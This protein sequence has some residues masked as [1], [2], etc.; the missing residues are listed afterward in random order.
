MNTT[1]YQ[2]LGVDVLRPTR[3]YFDPYLIYLNLACNHWGSSWI[4]NKNHVNTFI[5]QQEKTALRNHGH[6][7]S[8]RV[9][10]SPKRPR[11]HRLGRFYPL[12]LSLWIGR[13]TIPWKWGTVSISVNQCQSVSILQDSWP[14]HPQLMAGWCPFAEPPRPP[15]GL[16]CGCHI[17]DANG[18]VETNTICS[19]RFYNHEV[20]NKEMIRWVK[21]VLVYIWT[22]IKCQTI[23]KNF[24]AWLCPNHN[25]IVT[26]TYTEAHR[27]STNTAKKFIK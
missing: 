10:W 26:R 18:L 20:I 19:Y 14:Q 9:I 23:F 12:I 27:E 21:Q 15:C 22:S 17:S 16:P 13:I 11:I 24:P 2:Y 1:R 7:T 3:L 6:F 5:L 8:M 4:E 25:V